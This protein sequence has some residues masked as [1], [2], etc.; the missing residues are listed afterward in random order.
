MK[1][2][3]HWIKPI[4]LNNGKVAVN[5]HSFAIKTKRECGN[6]FDYWYITSY[7]PFDTAKNITIISVKFSVNI[8]YLHHYIWMPLNTF[9]ISRQ[10]V[11]YSELC[12]HCWGDHQWIPDRFYIHLGLFLWPIIQTLDCS[13]IWGIFYT[14]ISSTIFCDSSVIWGN[15]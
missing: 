13:G 12:E 9:T 14:C 6:E 3:H 5:I 7:L 2:V 10:V 8:L 15:I 11:W 1:L 4:Y